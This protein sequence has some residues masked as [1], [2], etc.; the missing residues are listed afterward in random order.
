MV[1]SGYSNQ[2]IA[3]ALYLSQQTIRNHLM[4]I[5][6]ELGV[7]N[8]LQLTVVAFKRGMVTVDEA[9]A[10]LAERFPQMTKTAE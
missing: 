10:A 1:A 2:E 8:R 7:N 3:E 6:R 5:F 9:Y 4:A